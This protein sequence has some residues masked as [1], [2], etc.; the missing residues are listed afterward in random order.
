MAKPRRCGDIQIN[1]FRGV[2][3]AAAQWLADEDHACSIGPLE[4]ISVVS[5]FDGQAQTVADSA[6]DF[7]VIVEA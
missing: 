4:D 1:N 5:H 6:G 7:I 3:N 2:G